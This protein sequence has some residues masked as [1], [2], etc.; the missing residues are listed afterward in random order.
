MSNATVIASVFGEDTNLYEILGVNSD[1]TAA[2]LRKG[3]Y[4]KALL[5]HPDKVPGKDEE[6]KAI[7]V[8][9]EIL[10]NDE[11]RK[12]YDET[13]EMNDDEDA[14][15]GD[16][17]NYFSSIFGNV[18]TSKIDSF[19]ERYKC[20]E[21]EESDVL[22]YYS[23]F[24]GNLQKMLQNVMLS[25]ER[26]AQRWV[27]DFITPAMESG[28]VSD[29][30]STLKRTLAKCQLVLERE[31]KS[32]QSN[33][34]EIDEDATES[35]ES[36]SGIAITEQKKRPAQHSNKN[37]RRKTKAEREA[38]EAEALFAK[39]RGKNNQVARKQRS[40]VLDGLALKYG[41]TAVD[42]DPLDDKEFEKIQA[43]LKKRSKSSYK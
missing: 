25:T 2:Q 36:D 14:R 13:G 39:I 8:A 4:R 18:T 30:S 10:K 7:T 20:S 38:E 41:G 23:Q 15:D 31:Q 3:Y 12:E 26:D 27:E 35:E 22:K 17:T 29:Y 40:A 11:S 34:N 43:R 5:C 33:V 37:K 32:L 16:W 28:E 1:A 19:A 6:F 21:E 42:N 9:Y 24:K